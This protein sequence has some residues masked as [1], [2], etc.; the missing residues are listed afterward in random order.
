M[1]LQRLEKKHLQNKIKRLQ[2]EIYHLT[3]P[4]INIEDTTQSQRVIEILQ[5]ADQAMNRFTA[6]LRKEN[7]KY[8]KQKQSKG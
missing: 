6:K 4:T 7:A 2:D 1:E 3:H 8:A 5:D